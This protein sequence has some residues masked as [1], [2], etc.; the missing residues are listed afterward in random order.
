MR[1]MT[2]STLTPLAD[3][4]GSAPLP[5]E[6]ATILAPEAQSRR[7]GGALVAALREIRGLTQRQVADRAAS[8][9]SW[10]SD[11]ERGLHTPRRQQ[12]AR[13]CNALELSPDERRTV[14][15]AFNVGGAALEHGLPGGV[16]IA[17]LRGR[18]GLSQQQVC[19]PLGLHLSWLSLIETGARK[20]TPNQV[21]ILGRLL[22]AS[23]EEIDAV[24]AAYG[25]P[26]VGDSVAQIAAILRSDPRLTRDAAEHLIA[27]VTQLYGDATT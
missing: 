4:L 11:L 14:F 8:T 10:V 21:E 13:L 12:L 5:P 1:R 3:P 26:V 9:Q 27:T 7:S 24:R 25:Y 15:E 6:L 22:G 2:I 18:A 19:A 23:R 17:R 16:Q 20:P